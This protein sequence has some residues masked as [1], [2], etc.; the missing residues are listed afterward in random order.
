MAEAREPSTHRK[1]IEEVCN[2]ANARA[3]GEFISRYEPFIRK[4]VRN[5]RRAPVDEDE[6]IQLVLVKLYGVLPRGRYDRSRRFRPWLLRLVQNTVKDYLRG[7][8]RA[9]DR[10]VGGSSAHEQRQNLPDPKEE[11]PGE[12]SVDRAAILRMACQNIQRLVSKDQWRAFY[13]T[14]LLERSGREVAD[15]MGMNV[16]A[17]HTAKCRV[18]RRIRDEV[19]RLLGMI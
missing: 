13:E 8:N 11:R 3:W 10:P 18:Q 14:T 1:L 6:V 9:P 12:E 2:P 4:C 5:Y 15:E 17:V 7:V 19:E 16:G